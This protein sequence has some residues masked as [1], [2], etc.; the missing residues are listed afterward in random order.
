MAAK[1]REH[2]LILATNS[3]VGSVPSRWE[4]LQ[5]ERQKDHYSHFIL[6]LAFAQSAELSR[7]FRSAEVRLFKL[8]WET[9]GLSDRDAFVESLGLDWERVSKQEK[10]ELRK[11]LEAGTVGISDIDV[12]GFLKVR[13]ERVHDLVEQRKVLV[14]GGN[15]Y[16]PVS[17]Q[18]S[19]VVAEYSAHLEKGLEVSS[20]ALPPEVPVFE[21]AGH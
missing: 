8:R 18:L 11:D 19:L 4:A 1:A 14:R 16:V 15:A 13:W 7:R 17:Q 5:L 12:E 20:T 2:H 10:S 21:R 9:D 3:S 6:R